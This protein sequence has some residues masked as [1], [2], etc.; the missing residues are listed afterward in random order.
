MPLCPAV[1]KKKSGE[2]KQQTH[3]KPTPVIKGNAVAYALSTGT[4]EVGGGD[5]E[6]KIFLVL[7]IHFE[8]I[9]S[10]IETIV[11]KQKL[12]VL[13]LPVF[14]NMNVPFI[15]TCVFSVSLLWPCSC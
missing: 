5:E 14:P 9:L 4:G 6:F 7:D 8:A 13:I 1:L 11:S 3:K 2:K 15:F 10:H 12:S